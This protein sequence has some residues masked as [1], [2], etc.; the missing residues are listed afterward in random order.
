MSKA[1]WAEQG[2]ISLFDVEIQ[3]PSVT[4]AGRIIHFI[5]SAVFPVQRRLVLNHVMHSSSFLN[6]R[7]N[8]Q[9]NTVVQGKY[10]AAT[11]WLCV[12]FR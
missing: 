5:R 6:D 9:H 3:F 4:S 1:L 2:W 7:A 10:I 8:S 11:S 12:P